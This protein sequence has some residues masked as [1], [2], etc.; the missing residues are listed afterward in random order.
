VMYIL[1][2]ESQ[3]LHY[4]LIGHVPV[5][6]FYWNKNQKQIRKEEKVLILTLK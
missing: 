5:Q 4:M 3:N 1:V 6:I 2:V